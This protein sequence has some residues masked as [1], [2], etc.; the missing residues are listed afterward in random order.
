MQ[1]ICYEPK[2]N[3][4][5][6]RNLF[7]CIAIVF[8]AFSCKPKTEETT[9]QVTEMQKKVNQ[10]ASFKLTTDVSRLTEKEKQM[11]P[12]LIEVADIMEDIYWQLAYGN[13][14]TLFSK[15][16]DSAAIRYA[17]INYGPWDRLDGNAPFVEGVGPKP[18]GANFYP[19]DMTKDEFE[20]LNDPNKTNW[21]TV[22][23][24][25]EN[26]QLKVV[27]YHEIFK[28]QMDK[29]SALLKQ[30]AELAEDADLKKYLQLRA[31]ALTTSDYL[32]S[33]LAWMDMKNNVIDFV[34]GP[35]ENYEDQLFGYKA[36][37]SGQILVKDV[38]WSKRLEKY[39]AMLP[40]LQKSLPVE[41][42]YKA[43]KVN[44]NPDNNVYDVIYYAGDCNAGSKNIAINLPNDPRVHEQKGSRKLQLK[45]AMQA[46][47]DK[48]M[49]PI[50]N[51]LID[52]AQRKYIKFDAFFENVM[53]HEVA[54]GLGVKNTIDGKLT[55]RDALKEA[56]APVE[57]NKADI[58]GLF[59]VTQLY[60]MGEMPEKDLMDNYV[61]FMAGIFRS[62][63]F[64]VTSAHGKANM[65]RF[66]YFKQ[67]G[68]FTRDSMS[69]TYFV[70][71]E[72]MKESMNSLAGRI[73]KVQ[74]DGNYA[75]AASWIANESGIDASL[76]SDLDRIA[77][78]GIPKDVIWEQ[79]IEVLGLK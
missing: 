48:I 47:F 45:N 61:T 66:N 27:W 26:K 22:I 50:A 58:L 77:N 46:K 23:R 10:Y 64:G 18:D 21:Y 79:G 53:F 67:T 52:S 32:A 19:Q 72:K 16:S 4:M 31:D 70:N 33:D 59:F 36:A 68:A 38:E 37:P 73:I 69:N 51:L 20:E 49:V 2:Q 29:A 34:V 5:K 39:A 9:N 42:K 63:R 75:E 35:I 3:N 40:A 8:L 54:H 12:L 25:D 15:L 1:Q 13:K 76:Q 62:I 78:A 11:L 43:E 57:E 17:Q 6:T 24:R 60:Q 7:F 30:A 41:P 55:V 71:F 56:Y 44:T 74:G 14:D 65:M 28:E